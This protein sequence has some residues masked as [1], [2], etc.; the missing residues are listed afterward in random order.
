MFGVRE[1]VQCMPM[2]QMWYLSAVS[3]F[4]SDSL[5]ILFPK[6]LS[7]AVMVTVPRSCHMK[8]FLSLYCD[9]S[10]A[11]AARSL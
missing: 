3:L 11:W 6:R 2:R 4:F 7:S 8:C 9:G 10:C 5:K 1:C